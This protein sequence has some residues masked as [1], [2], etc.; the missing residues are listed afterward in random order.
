MKLLITLQCQLRYGLLVFALLASAGMA[1]GQAFDLTVAQDGT[2]SFTTVQAA[3]NAAPVGRT[4]PFTIFIRNGRYKE[5]ISVPA[6]KTFLHFIGQ[7]VANTVLTFDDF[8]GKPMP[9]GGTYG[10]SNSASVIIN[11]ADFAAFNITFENTTGES[12]QALAINV[13]GDRAVFQGCR[14]LGGQDTVLS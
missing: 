10:T 13:Q 3:I 2:G 9:G 1:R 8:S 11:A 4:A 6:N 5:K 14:F 7:S 12:P